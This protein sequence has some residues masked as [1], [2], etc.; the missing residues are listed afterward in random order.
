MGSGVPYQFLPLG[1]FAQVASCPL[2]LSK[3]EIKVT[4]ELFRKLEERGYRG[5]IVPIQH[6]RDLQ[7]EIEAQYKQGLFDEEFYQEYLAELTFSPPDNFPDARTLV[8]VAVPHPQFQVT[9]TW[10][11]E[12]VPLIVPPTYLHWQETDKQVEDLLAEILGPQG[13]QL[14]QAA[15]PKKLLAVHSGLGA[16]GRNNVCYIDGMGSFHRLVAFYSVVP[17]QEDNWQELR[18]MESCQKCS[19]CLRNCPT[20]AITAERFL[21]RAEQCITFRNEK[22]GDVPFPAWLAPSWHNCLVGC[23]HCQSVC[24]QNREFWQWVEEGPRFSSKETTLLL[25][26]VPLDQLPTATVKKLERSG[27]VEFLDVLPRNL[28]VFLKG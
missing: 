5:Q 17:C 22:P 2:Y 18:M 21:L 12:P 20:G 27:L 16:Y 8:V 13:H 26:G 15:L 7:E 6:L 25:Q 4:Q 24:P 11:G 14:A 19:A 23:L 10:N 3:L 9:F 28:S 1:N